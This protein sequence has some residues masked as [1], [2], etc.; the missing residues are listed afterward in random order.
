MRALTYLLLIKIK[1]GLIQ[2]VKSPVKLIYT[3]FMV[4][5]LSIVLIAGSSSDTHMTQEY[6]N[7]E[8]LIGGILAV[9]ALIFYLTVNSG[10]NTGATI[11]K[12]PDIN[13]LFVSPY[14]PR[15]LLIYGV[16]QQLGTLLISGVFLVFQYAWSGAQR[17]LYSYRKD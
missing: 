6:L 7:R 16:I 14:H 17:K 15:T 2:F 3:I 13:L 4:A 9:Y 1:N 12:M 10:F 5:C 11:F 8:Y